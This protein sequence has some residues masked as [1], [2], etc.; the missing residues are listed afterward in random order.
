MLKWH[1]FSPYFP[2]SFDMAWQAK[3][4]VISGQ[5]VRASLA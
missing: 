1:V 3:S 2:F 4:K 5:L